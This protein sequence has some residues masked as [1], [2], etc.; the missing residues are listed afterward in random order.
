MRRQKSRGWQQTVRAKGGV[1]EER[2]GASP[3]NFRQQSMHKC[4][5][6]FILFYQQE[7]YQVVILW[8]VLCIQCCSVRYLYIFVFFKYIKN[9]SSNILNTMYDNTQDWHFWSNLFNIR[10]TNKTW[11]LSIICPTLCFHIQISKMPLIE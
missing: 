1:D 7:S 9:G 4:L 8:S 3:L 10:H 6:Y 11:I 5:F 2:S